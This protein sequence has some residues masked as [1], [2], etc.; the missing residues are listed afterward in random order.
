MNIY[1]FLFFPES[2]PT[3]LCIF[4]CIFV[5]FFIIVLICGIAYFVKKIKFSH[6][7]DKCRLGDSIEEVQRKMAGVRV[8]SSGK[9]Y[10]SY[11]VR[12]INGDYE[13]VDFYFDENRQLIDAK[14]SYR[15]THYRQY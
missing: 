4:L 5:P 15:E 12:A 7:V 8:V 11:S 6:K 1:N 13:R 2:M 3:G 10:I 14:H 9:N